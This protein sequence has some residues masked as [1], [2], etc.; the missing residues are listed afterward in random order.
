MYYFRVAICN[1]YFKNYRVT[2]KL[3]L[4]MCKILSLHDWKQNA[5]VNRFWYKYVQILLGKLYEM[6]VPISMV[7]ERS[8]E[9][10][11]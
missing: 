2:T 10:P 8:Y 9:N 5:F 3:D 11:G 7:S 4:L 1:K 6:D